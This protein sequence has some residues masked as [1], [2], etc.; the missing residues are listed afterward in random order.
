[1]NRE[2]TCGHAGSFAADLP[3]GFDDVQHAAGGR[4]LAAVDHAAAGLDRQVAFEREIG[5]LEEG[6]V[7][8][9]S[10]SLDGPVLDYLKT[11]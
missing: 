1:M 3:D 11:S 9:R 4:R 5:F 8:T 2:C 7:V 10:F 6:F